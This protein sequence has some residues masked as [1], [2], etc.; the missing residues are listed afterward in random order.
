MEKEIF[1]EVYLEQ[2]DEVESF[3][4]DLQSDLM[5][6]D[7][8]ENS[9][10]ADSF[11]SS[12]RDWSKSRLLDFAVTHSYDLSVEFRHLVDMMRS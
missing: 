12:V 5:L 9:S 11:S 4:L 1:K 7:L 6:L 2:V 3:L 8:V 10:R